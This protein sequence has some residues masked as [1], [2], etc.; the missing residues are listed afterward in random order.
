MFASLVVGLRQ[1]MGNSRFNQI[2]GKAIGLHCKVISNFC[3][4]IGIDSKERQNLI[5]LAR[6]NG[7]QLGFMA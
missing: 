7:K 6:N 1:L 4:F 3:N 5:R 2:R